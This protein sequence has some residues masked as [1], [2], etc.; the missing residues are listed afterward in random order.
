MATTGDVWPVVVETMPPFQTPG[1][2]AVVDVG[3]VLG[4][5]VG[6]LVGLVPDPML[7]SS[8]PLPP[9]AVNARLA[10]KSVR[11]GSREPK[12]LFMNISNGSG[13]WLSV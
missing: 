10:A 3:G 8:P 9:Q 11:T 4:V 6:G 1:V 2:V 5:P 12:G 7:E 13:N